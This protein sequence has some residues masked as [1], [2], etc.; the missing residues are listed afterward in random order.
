MIL[1]LVFLFI[2]VYWKIYILNKINQS[3]MELKDLIFVI[4]AILIA[5]VLLKIFFWLLPV[6]VVLVI[7]FFIYIYLQ[8]HYWISSNAE[9]AATAPSPQATTHCF[10]P[11]QTSPTAYT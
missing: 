7:A 6:L 10:K 4:A 11:T 3:Y 2:I 9:V 1:F 5:V 8:E